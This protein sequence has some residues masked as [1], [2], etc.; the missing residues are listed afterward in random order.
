VAILSLRQSRQVGERAPVRLNILWRLENR[1]GL[2]R[3]GI[4]PKDEELGRHR[5]EIDNPTD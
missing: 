1:P 5:A 2:A 4:E 3:I